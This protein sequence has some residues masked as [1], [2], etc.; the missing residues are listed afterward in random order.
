MFSITL[1][2]KLTLALWG[3]KTKKPHKKQSEFEFEC[4][5]VCFHTQTD[6]LGGK[7]KSPTKNSVSVSLSARMF[8]SQSNPHPH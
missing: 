3:G 5:D 7:Q 6:P 4:E 2:P 1:K 8:V